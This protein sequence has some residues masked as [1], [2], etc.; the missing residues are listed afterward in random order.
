MIFVF[1]AIAAAIETA[2]PS[3]A[4][5]QVSRSWIV[6]P[7]SAVILD[8]AMYAPTRRA[9]D[10]MSASGSEWFN[11]IAREPSSG[12]IPCSVIVF[13]SPPS[14]TESWRSSFT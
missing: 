14:S 10:C 1:A 5:S 8:V 12:R 2:T 3:S 6:W 7:P 11:R 9:A 4:S 13:A